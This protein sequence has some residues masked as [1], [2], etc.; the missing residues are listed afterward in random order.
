MRVLIAIPTYNEADNLA[1]LIPAIRAAISEADILVIDDSSPDGTKAVVEGLA[2]SGA[3]VHLICREAERGYGTA[4]LRGLN[5]GI[6]RGYDAV[7][8]LDAD[9]SHDPED[10]PALV[11]GLDDADI[12]IGSRYQGGV[13]VL[14]WGIQRLL[15]SLAANSYVK[16]LSGLPCADCTSGFRAYR[17]DLLA[18]L[19][20][21][22]VASSGYALLPEILFELSYLTDRIREHPVCFTE[23][24]VGASKM[25]IR[26]V[27][28]AS[29]R[30]WLLLLTRMIRACGGRSRPAPA[31]PTMAAKSTDTSRS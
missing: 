3:R 18:K 22:R 6:A 5:E 23:R 28:E 29:A 31:L 2:R 27:M 24:R 30:P 26:V 8:T 9:F 10:I 12:V 7:V 14:N 4:V 11:S 25:S 13:R 20:M 16:L 17:V 21:R 15:L 19:S 1:R